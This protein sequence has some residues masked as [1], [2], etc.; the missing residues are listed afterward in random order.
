MSGPEAA[1][2]PGSDPTENGSI[3]PTS[4]VAVV[5]CRQVDNEAESP[6]YTTIPE[7][8]VGQRETL[9]TIR[10]V[11]NLTV[12]V[13]DTHDYW[14]PDPA[15][16]LSYYPNIF[17]YPA[18]GGR[19]TC[20]GRMFLSTEDRPR[21]GMK[22]LV[23][24]T[25]QLLR[26]GE[27]GPSVLRWHASMGGARR[28]LLRAPPAPDPNLYATVGEGFLFHRGS[29][30]P[31]LLIANAEQWEGAVQSILDL[32]RV[33]PTSLVSLGAVL[34]FPYFLPEQKTN[35]HEFAEQLPLALALMRV[36]KG[37]AQGD[38]H[39]KRI[40]AWESAPFTVRDLTKGI[41]AAGKGK[42]APPLVFQYVRDHQDE[43]LGQI[44]QRVDLVE[45]PRLKDQLADPER[46]GG[47]DRR[48]VM[49]RIGTA[50]ESAAILLSRG[51]G[52]PAS[53]SS[54]VARRANEYLR[55]RPSDAAGELDSGRGEPAIAAMD[56]SLVGTLPPWLQR[57]PEPAAPAPT[58]PE[59]VP[60][61]VSDDP[62][63][64]SPQ[65]DGAA[66]VVFGALPTEPPSPTVPARVDA[67]PLT[68]PPPPPPVADMSN[69][70]RE[71]EQ[72]VIRYIDERLRRFHQELAAAGTVDAT[73]LASI[74]S[75]LQNLD[76]T[77]RDQ[78]ATAT[79]DL[80]ARLS[81]RLT[82]VVAA[83][84]N[85]QLGNVETTRAA[86]E[87]RIQEAQD[88][89][90]QALAQIQQQLNI[91][92]ERVESGLGNLGSQ[93]GAELEKRWNATADPRIQE[94]TKRVD[95]NYRGA[96]DALARDLRAEVA[97]SVESMRKEN[98]RVEADMRAGLLAQLELHLRETGGRDAQVRAE[99]EAH[100]R[101]LAQQRLADLERQRAKELRESEQRL[102]LLVEGRAKDLQE[103]LTKLLTA[104][105]ERNS[106]NLE[107]RLVDSES[108]WL[109]RVEERA[110]AQS[111]TQ[112]HALAEL[113][114]RMQ[115]YADQKLREVQER[116]RE[117]YIELLARLKS[118]VDT[119]LTKI[120][121]STRF[122][123]AVRERVDRGFEKN[124][125]DAQRAF[126]ARLVEAE[127]RL[128]RS[129]EEGIHRLELVEG[130]VS[131]RE[132]DLLR[133]EQKIH[134]EIEE[135]DHRTQVLA[136]RLVPVVRQAWLKI[137]EFQKTAGSPEDLE[138][139]LKELRRGFAR[140]LRRVEGELLEQTAEIR[141]RMETAIS[142]Q[143]RVW[144]TLVRQLTQLSETRRASEEA[145][146]TSRRREGVRLEEEIGG[147]DELPEVIYS[148]PRHRA[149]PS[150]SLEAELDGDDDRS[151]RDDL[152]EEEPAP[153]RRIRRS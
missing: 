69:L 141:D 151:A 130:R 95:E 26:S 6:G 102:N 62:S 92:I 31:V 78:V 47:K 16:P 38:R 23:L 53:P 98:A 123:A 60:V 2:T 129:D 131:E 51:R 84:S 125:A 88:T 27:F 111:E 74:E 54:E 134:E 35:L 28:E 83:S 44:A 79:K 65:P 81:S 139:Q 33:L 9:D 142:N 55:A 61:S 46:Q 149:T 132:K 67:A 36:A 105:M 3:G 87:R 25:Q 100:V 140:E 144:L 15:Q 20:V 57:G 58:G 94:L 4:P 12:N 126:E 90:H 59:S 122:D 75:R 93:V 104:E 17:L 1:G 85:A 73:Q 146:A 72:D 13:A 107:Q 96:S 136:D 19:Y 97:R 110:G 34:T 42:D 22:T 39:D 138:L 133:I 66:S 29:T 108:R 112:G 52:K 121:D 91:R 49:W 116:E 109:A 77:A 119:S 21:L 45:I 70:R 147:F 106:Q 11:G 124:R 114:V 14:D 127:D 10:L 143:G 99:M 128:R 145:R 71:I 135:L 37:E 63:L 118:E 82:A 117:N 89:Q 5:W 120:V 153:R 148:R 76:A 43:K 24:D 30:D 113:Q 32:L 150:D 40:A 8:F 101:D 56:T 152:D 86:V 7:D 115:S 68:I 41:P 50:F 48:K 64:L 18:F 103:R 80:E 137:Q